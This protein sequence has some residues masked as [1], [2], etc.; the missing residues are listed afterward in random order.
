MVLL[1]DLN[2]LG[3]SDLVYLIQYM[4]QVLTSN[5]IDNFLNY[6]VIEKFVLLSKYS[7]K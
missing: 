1:I 2:V 5:F 7:H 6:S 4:R 3:M